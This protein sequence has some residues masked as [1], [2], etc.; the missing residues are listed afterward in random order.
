[1][2]KA[3]EMKVGDAVEFLSDQQTQKGPSSGRVI[4]REG[5][6]VTV[7]HSDHPGEVFSVADL[8]VDKL[9]SHHR[10]GAPLWIMK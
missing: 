5:L 7:Q 8:S 6:T 2:G 9:S 10:D 4:E 1:M 3:S